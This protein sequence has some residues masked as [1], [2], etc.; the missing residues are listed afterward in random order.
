[1]TNIL[2]IFVATV[3]LLLLCTAC[4][5]SAPTTLETLSLPCLSEPVGEDSVVCHELSST[6]V[7]ISETFSIIVTGVS[8]S[9]TNESGSVSLT[10]YAANIGSTDA[11]I[12]PSQ[13]ELL[14]ATGNRFSIA[15]APRLGYGTGGT[16]PFG[17]FRP[18]EMSYGSVRFPTSEPVAFPVVL[19][20]HES[21]ERKTPTY[22]LIDGE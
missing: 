9:S 15:P 8:L 6:G 17:Y 14:T 22:I 20:G 10:M 18:A 2:S 4:T 12:H 5:Q 1:M 11:E 19:V 7:P 3:S 16:F 21:V 13:L